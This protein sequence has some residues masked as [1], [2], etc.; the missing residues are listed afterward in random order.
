MNKLNTESSLDTTEG[1]HQ[2]EMVFWDLWKQ[3]KIAI[4]RLTQSTS[5]ETGY[6][7]GLCNSLSFIFNPLNVDM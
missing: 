1:E 7:G 3:R 2:K 4:A 6:V 5:Q